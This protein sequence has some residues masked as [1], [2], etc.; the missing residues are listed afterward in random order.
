VQDQTRVYTL[1]IWSKA[2]TERCEQL[3]VT[4]RRPKPYRAEYE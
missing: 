2:A 4:D 1:T 3:V